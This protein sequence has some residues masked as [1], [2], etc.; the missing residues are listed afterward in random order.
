MQGAHNLAFGVYAR[1]IDSGVRIGSG[2]LAVYR[3]D[4]VV[5]RDETLTYPLET[6]A[7]RAATIP[8]VEAVV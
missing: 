3:G 6:L 8:G 2:H 4:Y 5:S 1:M 7:E